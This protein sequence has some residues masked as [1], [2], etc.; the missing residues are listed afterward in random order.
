MLRHFSFLIL[1]LKWTLWT[2]HGFLFANGHWRRALSRV[3]LLTPLG[4]SSIYTLAA[5]NVPVLAEMNL[6]ENHDISFRRNEVLVYD[7]EGQV[8]SVPLRRSPSSHRITASCFSHATAGD[9]SEDSREQNLN[10]PSAFM[11]GL[12]RHPVAQLC[13]HANPAPINTNRT[14]SIPASTHSENDVF[15]MKTCASHLLS[16]RSCGRSEHG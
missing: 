9:F 2:D 1:A 13:Q 16:S 8:R 5:A 10:V 14:W 15:L 4:W 3:R 7:A 6:L 12:S 11:Y